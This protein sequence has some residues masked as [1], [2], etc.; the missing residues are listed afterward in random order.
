MKKTGIVI[1]Q[2][3]AHK[4]AVF[5]LALCLN[6]RHAQAKLW[7]I[8]RVIKDTIKWATSRESLST[9]HGSSSRQTFSPAVSKFISLNCPPISSGSHEAYLFPWFQGGEGY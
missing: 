4:R 9:E 2:T 1:V 8:A 3:P 5:T 7:K 6:V